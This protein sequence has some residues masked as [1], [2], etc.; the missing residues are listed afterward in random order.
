MQFKK[1]K[2]KT[3]RTNNN[4]MIRKEIRRKKFM[5]L[6]L[7]LNNVLKHAMNLN[8]RRIKRKLINEPEIILKLDHPG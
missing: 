8:G 1:S 3:I 2:D 6:K 4:P 7:K 5:S